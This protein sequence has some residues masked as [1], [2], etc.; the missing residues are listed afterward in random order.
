MKRV[1]DLAEASLTQ[2]AQLKK[3]L[4]LRNSQ[5]HQHFG[6]IL[7]KRNEFYRRDVDCRRNYDLSRSLA[8]RS[9]DLEVIF[10]WANSGENVT[11]E[12]VQGLDSLESENETAE[13]KKMLGW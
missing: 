2:S 13:I 5:R 1:A 12:L 6:T 9:E 4:N 10:E 8:Q 3:F 11:N 7:L